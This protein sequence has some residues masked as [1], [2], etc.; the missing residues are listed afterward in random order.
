MMVGRNPHLS[1]VK[2]VEMMPAFYQDNS[3]VDHVRLN[4]DGLPSCFVSLAS[5]FSLTGA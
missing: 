5:P 2:A 3:T 1:P 4:A